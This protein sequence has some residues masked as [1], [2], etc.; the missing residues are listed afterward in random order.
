MID[1][2][3]NGRIL[4][5]PVVSKNKSG[6]TFSKAKMRVQTKGSGEISVNAIAY[7]EYMFYA[8]LALSEGDDVRI[9]GPIDAGAYTCPSGRPRSLLTIT[10]TKILNQNI[11]RQD[12]QT[13]SGE[14]RNNHDRIKTAMIFQ[15]PNR[16]QTYCDTDY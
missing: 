5:K 10:A 1:A 12:I 6:L 15:S 16:P 14:C 3:V 11:N 9:W 4:E 2:I 8:L 13:T 7:D